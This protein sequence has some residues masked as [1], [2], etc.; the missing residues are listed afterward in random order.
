MGTVISSPSLPTF[1]MSL[2]RMTWVGFGWVGGWGWSGVVGI[3]GS[4]VWRGGG[5]DGRVRC[6]ATLRGGC[7]GRDRRATG[8]QRVWHLPAGRRRRPDDDTGPL[9]GCQRGC[10]CLRPHSA[11]PAGA[12][13]ALWCPSIRAAA[14]AALAAAAAA[15]RRLRPTFTLLQMPGAALPHV[16]FVAAEALDGDGGPTPAAPTWHRLL[17]AL[18]AAAWRRRRRLDACCFYQLPMQLLGLR[19]RQ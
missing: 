8:R 1:S 16:D 11:A 17:P 3:R 14:A 13:A 7:R 12:L 10:C 2:V 6:A 5:W 4:V 9:S 15:P 19:Q 18:A